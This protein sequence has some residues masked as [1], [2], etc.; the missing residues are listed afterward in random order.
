[1]GELES[2]VWG[3]AFS[4]AGVAAPCVTAGVAGIV[5]TTGVTGASVA[6]GSVAGG[7]VAAGG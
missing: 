6:G 3:R 5:G 7:S 4:S 2:P 1:M